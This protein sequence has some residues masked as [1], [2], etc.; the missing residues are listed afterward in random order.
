MKHNLP[1][2]LLAVAVLAL[3]FALA[4]PALAATDHTHSYKLVATRKEPTCTTAGKGL[5]RCECGHQEMRELPALG[6]KWGSWKTTKAATC[7]KAGTQQHV[8][9]RCGETET[10]TVKATGHSYEWKV[11]KKATCGAAGSRQQVCKVCGA[12]GKT[13]TIKATGKHTYEWKVTKK[14]TCGE[15]GSR[16]QVCKVCGAKGKTETIKATGMHTYEWKVTKKATCGEAGSRQQVCKMCGAKGKTEAIKATGQHTY[17]WK[18]TKQ[19]TCGEAGS[20]QQVC[21]VC[22]A[23]GRAEKIAATGKH[24][25]GA[26]TVSKAAACEEAGQESRACSVCGK[27]EIRAVD[28]LGHD[29]DHGVV[30]VPAG[31]LETGVKTCTCLRCG[32]TKTEEVPV[33]QTM[34]GQ[35]I[36]DYF[37]NIPPDAASSDPLRIVTQPEG[38]FISKDGGSLRLSVEVEG[39]AKPYTYVWR[40]KL[41]REKLFGYIMTWRTFSEGESNTCDA[42]LGDFRYYCQV[43]DDEGHQVNSDEVVVGYG[44]FIDQQPQNANLYGK[45]SVTLSCTAAGGVPFGDEYSSP[46]YYYW[47]DSNGESAGQGQTVTIDHEGVYSCTVQDAGGNEVTSLTATVYSAEKLTIQGL[48][49]VMPEPGE[50]A[51]LIATVT[52][53]VEPYTYEWE[54]TPNENAVSTPDGSLLPDETGASITVPDGKRGRYQLTVTDDMGEWT[55]EWVQVKK[56]VEPLTILSTNLEEVILDYDRGASWYVEVTD[57]TQPY[58]YTLL[59]ENALKESLETWNTDH[60]FTIHE[61]GWYA[62]HIEDA[63]GRVAETEYAQVKDKALKIVGFTRE[64]VLQAYDKN[65]H[66][67][68]VKAEGGVEPYSYEWEKVSEDLNAIETILDQDN[69]A[70]NPGRMREYNHENRQMVVNPYSIWKC[71]VTD[72]VGA[73]A[74]AYPMEVKFDAP[75]AIVEHPKSVQVDQF[76]ANGLP[77]VHF[78][79]KAIGPEGHPLEYTWQE[80]GIGGW[81]S[82]KPSSKN[83][84]TLTERIDDNKHMRYVLGLAYRCVVRDTVT[85][86]EVT[87]MEAQVM[88]PILT[89]R[90]VDN[91]VYVEGG[92]G[93]YTIIVMNQKWNTKGFMNSWIVPSNKIRMTGGDGYLSAEYTVYEKR[94]E[95]FYVTVTD[96]NGKRRSYSTADGR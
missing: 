54:Y 56:Y 38:G 23:K 9:T 10:K 25:F 19:A 83:S 1:K 37:R 21:K 68:E 12:K 30:T 8:C 60:T 24:T 65:E 44:L 29:W 48:S 81:H 11:T 14:A 66:F 72:Y 32:A 69:D 57:G 51:E 36:M 74:V 95:Y 71:T 16:Q 70:I 92:H 55:S 50:S 90:M 46:Y 42:D 96:S 49:D 40:R 58:T 13:E 20:R 78:A 63:E 67:L 93:P 82:Y 47:F 79:C 52:G 17:E 89:V 45:D 27:T 41:N 31:Y 73:K 6:H 7:T 80:K 33:N 18:V 77:T 84:I 2:L 64:L 34:S 5:Y 26:W 91:T 75:L 59:K 4:L 87:S 28:P 35:N 76:G 61:A 88:W 86:K 85:G 53:G 3:L 43:Y 15:A 22:G 39:G 94:K 62:L